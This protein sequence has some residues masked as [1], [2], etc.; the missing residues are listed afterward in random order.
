MCSL[1]YIVLFDNGKHCE[2]VSCEPANG[3]GVGE[4]YEYRIECR[5]ESDEE[6]A[7]SDRLLAAMSWNMYILSN[8]NARPSPHSIYRGFAMVFLSCV[9][10]M[11]MRMHNI[12]TTLIH[13][14]YH[15]NFLFLEQTIYVC[16]YKYRSFPLWSIFSNG[17]HS[18]S[19]LNRAQKRKLDMVAWNCLIS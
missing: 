19:R 7:R 14:R 9:E 6:E 15:T 1:E 13:M 12:N 4:K 16:T 18:R 3:D 10:T 8:S 5:S 2:S 11:L 17:A